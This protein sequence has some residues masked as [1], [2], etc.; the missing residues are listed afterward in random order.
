MRISDWS[1]D[2]GSSDLIAAGDV[3][4]PVIRAIRTLLADHNHLIRTLAIEDGNAASAALSEAQALGQSI[5]TSPTAQQRQLLDAL[6]VQ[7]SIGTG[8]QVT[9]SYDASKLANRLGLDA[10]HQKTG[11]ATLSIVSSIMRKSEAQRV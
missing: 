10:D 7:V 1:S 4:Q 6:D 9:A 3:E 8:P 5:A 2:V 11:R